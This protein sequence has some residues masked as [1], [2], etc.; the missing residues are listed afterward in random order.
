MNKVMRGNFYILNFQAYLFSR[1]GTNLMKKRNSLNDG[2]VTLERLLTI[3]D[4]HFLKE[5]KI[6]KNDSFLSLK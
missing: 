3:R 2:V 1:R 5:R 6:D 4:S